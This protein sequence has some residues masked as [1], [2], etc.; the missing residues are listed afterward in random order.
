MDR[1]SRFSI[2]SWRKSNDPQ[3]TPS[4]SPPV[5]LDMPGEFIYQQEYEELLTSFA[6][7]FGMPYVPINLIHN[8]IT[9]DRSPQ[10]I[11]L[12]TH[13]IGLQAVVTALEHDFTLIIPNKTMTLTPEYLMTHM[14]RKKPHEDT[15]VTFNG[16]YGKIT[17]DSIALFSDQEPAFPWKCIPDI[18]FNFPEHFYDNLESKENLVRRTK[19]T[20]VI[21]TDNLQT[22]LGEVVVIFTEAPLI[23]NGCSWGWVNDELQRGYLWMERPSVSPLN[24]NISN[25]PKWYQLPS[26]PQEHSGNTF[27]E[28][29]DQSKAIQIRSSLENSF[30]QFR[31]ISNTLQF[32]E[33]SVFLKQMITGT[34]R[35]IERN[36][37]WKNSFIEEEENIMECL[38]NIYTISL[39][40]LL[41]PPCFEETSKDKDKKLEDFVLSRQFLN[42]T[43]IGLEFLHDIAESVIEEVAGLLRQVNMKRSPKEKGKVLKDVYEVVKGIVDYLTDSNEET[44]I[45]T[46]AF[47]ILKTNISFLVTT[48]DYIKAFRLTTQENWIFDVVKKYELAIDQIMNLNVN[49]VKLPHTSFS[50]LLTKAKK[51]AQN[52]IG[53]TDYF[54]IKPKHPQLP[55]IDIILNTDKP[56]DLTKEEI[57]VLLT[58]FKGALK[59]NRQLNKEI[60]ILEQKKRQNEQNAIEGQPST[61]KEQ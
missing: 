36:D 41:W 20:T 57:E 42:A 15:F 25:N 49:N 16:L 7:Q 60:E 9:V 43:D 40:E 35:K 51:K 19:E 56:E 30:K 54:S 31:N 1:P 11:Y 37:V 5:E 50:S 8:T 53:F 26:E 59:E 61:T 24:G 18:F 58:S 32:K 45:K 6:K 47:I 33:K 55:N 28:K 3:P 4:I 46:L 34:K 23:F 10:I 44:Y 52:P 13:K 29:L 39:Y 38:E 12:L 22:P 21:C 2:K 14:I 27:L 17:N 48:L